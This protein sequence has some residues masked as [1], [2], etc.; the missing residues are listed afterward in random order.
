MSTQTKIFELVNRAP[1]ASHQVLKTVSSVAEVLERLP[2]K[3][4]G[5]VRQEDAAKRSEER[6][7]QPVISTDPPYYDN[8]AYADLSDLWRRPI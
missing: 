5:T 4:C 8:V 1:N 2:D 7:D 6:L 3:R